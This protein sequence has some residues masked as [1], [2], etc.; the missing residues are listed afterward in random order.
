MHVLW[1][2]VSLSTHSLHIYIN[3]SM[4][5]ASDDGDFSPVPSVY[6][7]WRDIRDRVRELIPRAH[8]DLM[9]CFL[10]AGSDARRSLQFSRSALEAIVLHIAQSHAI[11]LSGDKVAA[12][13]SQLEAGKAIHGRIRARMD[14]I[15]M[16]GNLAVHHGAELDEFDSE[17]SAADLFFIVEWLLH[18]PTDASANGDVLS[19]ELVAGLAL[20]R[21][22]LEVATDEQKAILDTF[23]THRRVAISGCAGSGKT[24]LALEKAS[25]L[26]KAGLRVLC[27]CHNP[28]LSD[29]LADALVYTNV[30]V[31]TFSKFV[32][33]LLELDN[34]QSEWSHYEDITVDEIARAF[35]AAAANEK[36]DAIIIDEAQDFKEDWWLVVEASIEVRGFLYLFFDS[37]QALLPLRAIYPSIE[38]THTLTCNVRN[39]SEIAD[40]VSRVSQIPLVIRPELSGGTMRVTPFEKGREREAL[41]SAVSSIFYAGLLGSAAIVVT[42]AVDPRDSSIAGWSIPIQPRWSWQKAVKTAAARVGNPTMT[43]KKPFAL[44]PKFPFPD[45]S[46][47]YYPL[48]NDI[49]E[50]A[51]WARSYLTRHKSKLPD[52]EGLVSFSIDGD[53]IEVMGSHSPLAIAQF[54]SN[55]R[56]AE[57]LPK[58]PPV[59]L[60]AMGEA[61]EGCCIPLHSAASV[62]GLEYDGIITHIPTVV[63]DLK[64]HA[65]VALSRARL[66]QELLILKEVTHSLPPLT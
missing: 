17:R 12:H 8:Y 52:L 34:N 5:A 37:D 2:A 19:P 65:Y 42:D 46:D 57:Q 6:E 18:R 59:R 44:Q 30:Q 22:R 29:V 40:V 21:K 62:K 49:T 7:R 11:E 31:F 60:I 54:F 47:S 55:D 48:E 4:Q 36:Y 56:W 16:F 26:D 51:R 38:C 58:Q 28:Y 13:I 9:M 15:R 41:G 63:P 25:R 45:L 3:N 64:A 10:C 24:I 66:H 50:I 33:H 39:S 1:R 53:Q 35:D 43:T 23:K 20:L 32:H 61:M 14:S 27:L